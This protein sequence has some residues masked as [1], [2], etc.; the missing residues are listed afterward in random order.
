M[1]HP[2]TPERLPERVVADRIKQEIDDTPPQQYVASRDMREQPPPPP[3][4][5][6]NKGWG[7]SGLDLMNSGAAFWQNYSGELIIYKMFLSSPI[8]NIEFL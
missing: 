7:Y 3:L 6:E 8:N 1:I 5:Q 2:P 4:P